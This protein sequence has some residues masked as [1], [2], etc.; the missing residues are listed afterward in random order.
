MYICNFI[1]GKK[2]DSAISDLELVIKKKKAVPF[3]GEIPHRRDLGVMSGRYP[4]NASKIFI[5]ILKGLR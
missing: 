4:I 3:K 2:I 5:Q 1:R